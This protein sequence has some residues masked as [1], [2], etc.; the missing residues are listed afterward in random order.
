MM[1]KATYECIVQVVIYLLKIPSHTGRS[2][3]DVIGLLAQWC[4]AA[5]RPGAMCRSDKPI[6]GKIHTRQ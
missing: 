5:T 2:L 1:R 4:K 6:S 3:S